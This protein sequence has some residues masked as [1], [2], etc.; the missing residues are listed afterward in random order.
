VKSAACPPDRAKNRDEAAAAHQSTEGHARQRRVEPGILCAL[1]SVRTDRGERTLPLEEFEELVRRGE[2]A[3]STPVRFPLVTGDRWVD[4][5]D[6]ELFRRLYEPARIYF[7]RAFSLAGFPVVT[8]ALVVLQ[9]VLFGGLSGPNRWIELDTLIRAGAKVPANVM[10]LGQTWRLLTANLLHRDLLHLL[11]NMFFLFNLGGTIENAYRRQ[12]FALILV[13]SALGTTFTSNIMSPLVSV[14]ASG[15][16]LGLFGAAMIFGYKYADILPRRYRRYLTGAV[17]PYALFIL[18]VGLATPQTDNWGHLGGLVAGLIA[19]L[20][21]EPK[22]LLASRPK[23]S[24]WFRNA[25]GITAVSLVGVVLAMGPAIRS[26][27]AEL[28]TLEDPESGLAVS[29]PARWRFGANHLGYA[30]WGNSLGTSIGLRARRRV[31][32]PRSLTALRDHFLDEELAQREAAGAVTS[33]RVFGERPA[34]VASGRALEVRVGLESRAGPQLTRNII[35]ERGYYSYHVVLTAPGKHATAYEPLFDRIAR[36]VRLIEPERL[37]R[38]RTVLETFPGMSSAHVE[39]GHELATIRDVP[40]AAAAYKRA[41]KALPEQE[42]ALYG[43]AKLAVDYGGD[44]ESAEG[45][46][47]RLHERR[48]A[49]VAVASLLA[50]LRERLGQIDGARAVLQGTLDR[51]PG[52]AELREQLMRLEARSSPA[53]GR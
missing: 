48:P 24:F 23:R 25:P 31:D 2:I 27:P 3:P 10:E 33:V 5:K 36:S 12:D 7:A 16:V 8:T 47:A 30:S 51:T 21:L 39:L 17:L 37:S 49:D 34:L 6:L 14:G 13:A 29:Y 11:F 45:I 19:A 32:A 44:L 15:V 42:D 53:L 41:L 20:P 52:A 26:V 40:A 4:A 38:A 46:A 22:L 50:D 35:I 9:V 43:L 1:I 18:Y 28:T